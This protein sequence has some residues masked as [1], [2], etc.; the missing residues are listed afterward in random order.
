MIC[1]TLARR[2]CDRLS[3]GFSCG[4]SSRRFI[5]CNLSPALW[6]DPTSLGTGQAKWTFCRDLLLFYL[7]S[8]TV[9]FFFFSK[10]TKAGRCVLGL[11]LL[12][13]VQVREFKMEEVRGESTAVV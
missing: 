4:A 7:E 6:R 5:I 10:V 9:L 2:R 11:F 3:G 1:D 13:V 12:L 8:K